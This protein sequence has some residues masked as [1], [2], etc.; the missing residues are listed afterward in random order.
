MVLTRSIISSF[1]LTLFKIKHYLELHSELK[2][3]TK[4]LMINLGFI[5]S[6]SIKKKILISNALNKIF[7]FNKKDILVLHDGV[8]TKNFIISKSIKKFKTATYIGSFLKGRGIEIII[9]L[10][11]KFPKIN[12]ELYGMKDKIF[13]TNIKNLNFHKFVNYKKVPNILQ[14]SDIL[15]MP[16]SNDVEIRAKNINTANYCSPLK[17]FDYLAS[18]KIIISSKLDGICEVLINKQNAIIVH[19]Y[20][21]N[22]WVKA[23]NDLI[24][25]KFDNKKLKMQFLQQKNIVGTI[26]QI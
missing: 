17:M 23:F 5:K 9:E 12:F 25:N 20:E 1:F 21:V 26:D 18:G 11:K 2:S 24:S 19:D 10:A 14:K 4:I 16:Y 13:K 8:D 22:Y 15:L 3:F 7:K 6:Q